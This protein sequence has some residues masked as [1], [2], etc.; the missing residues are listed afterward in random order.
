M[1]RH[2]AWEGT[3]GVI[4]FRGARHE[5]YDK[6]IS[7]MKLDEGGTG[8]PVLRCGNLGEGIPQPDP[9]EKKCEGLSKS[10]SPYTEDP[11]PY[12]EDS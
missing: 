11:G 10:I 7:V 4:E 9:D 2:N 8:T 5:P 6:V 12:T 3:G 1:I